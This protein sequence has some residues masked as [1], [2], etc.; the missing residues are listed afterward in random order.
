MT[1]TTTQTPPDHKAWKATLAK[2]AARRTLAETD[3]LTTVAA[4][5]ETVSQT[6]LAVAL[7]TSQA[8]VSRWAARGRQQA[9]R[10]PP[11]SLGAD[12]YEIAQRYALGEIPRDETIAVL[13]AWPYEQ[14]FVPKHYWDDLGVS[15]EGGFRRTVGR[16]HREG[17]LSGTDYD[18]ILH[19]MA[20]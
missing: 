12:P 4:T 18:A 15:P 20:D 19:A 5:S 7:H 6:E 8:N 13:A 3:F 10:H 16:A 17:L 11:G 1:S 2:A 14:D 9:A